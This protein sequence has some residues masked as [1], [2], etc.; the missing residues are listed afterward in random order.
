M[1][2]YPRRLNVFLCLLTAISSLF[3]SPAWADQKA[4]RVLI[5]PL[6]IH[7]EKDL[8]FLN[9]GILDMLAARISQSAEVI[10]K[11]A[12]APGKDPV[13]MASDLNADYVITGSLTVFG[14]SASTDAALTAVDSGDTALLFSQFGQNGGDVLMHVNQFATQV[15]DYLESLSAAAPRVAAP[16]AAAP[17]VMIPQAASPVQPVQP[18]PPAA[19]ASPRAPAAPAPAAAPVAAATAA[20]PKTAEP[21]EALWTSSP[22]PGT[23]S[24]LATGDV[25]G[26]GRTDIVFAHGNRI[27]VEHRNGDRLDRLA[28]IDAGRRHRIVAVDAGD[29]NGN[30]AAEI[31]VTRLDV[32]GKLDSV[33]LEWNGATL[34]PIAGDQ[35]W[36][37]RVTDVPEIGM[38]LMG[39][40]R[41]TPSS[42]DTGGLYAYTHFL[43]GVFELAWTG[44]EYQAGRR[45]PLPD[46][47]TVYQFARGDIFN[48][49]KVR[50][51]AYSDADKLRI[52]DPTGTPQWAGEE[53]LGGSPLFLENTS[54]S[55]AIAKDRTYLTQR[56]IAADL[57]GDGNVEVVTVHNR[58]AARG[59]VERFRK[60]TRGRVIALR[61]N[62]VDMKQ[63]WTGEEISGYISDF[64]LAD[65]NGD[66]RLEA[67]YAMVVST[68]L[69][70]SKSSSIVVEQIGP[71]SGK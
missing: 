66:G 12:P 70:Q 54:A 55:G 15:S 28:A 64:S 24:A 60:Y 41:G 45:I 33:V 9:K 22:F 27:V 62:K 58:D 3:I 19:A 36:Y 53:T 10:R 65:L 23:I 32:H 39:Q 68:G 11:D 1:K 26:D 42:N 14:N 20:A 16:P 8:T 48:D 49:G 6:T 57:D 69:A 43:P 18:L 50:T 21:S 59:F 37:F 17:A 7:S 40:R 56:L 35:S 31:F 52:L 5:L 63:I 47:M 30:G 38:V 71:L 29:V 2:R 44:N 25:N 13:R 61:W 51:M 34:A 46:E 67:V 4:K